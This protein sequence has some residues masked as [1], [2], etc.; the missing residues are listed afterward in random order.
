MLP[1]SLLLMLAVL[2]Q[3]FRTDGRDVWRDRSS[4]GWSLGAAGLVIASVLV[5]LVSGAAPLVVLIAGF[6]VTAAL[7]V[8]LAFTLA[9]TALTYLLGIGGVGLI[10]LPIKILGGVDSF[11]LLAIPLFILAG[12]LMESGGISEPHKPRAPHRR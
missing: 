6:L 9:L 2:A 1:A 10:I 5:P 11:V 4:L 8:P 7:G 3:Q 12:A